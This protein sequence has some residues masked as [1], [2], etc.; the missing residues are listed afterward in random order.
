MPRS[1]STFTRRA[2]YAPTRIFGELIARYG[3][4]LARTHVAADA[5]IIW[6]P[7]LFA[8]GSLNGADFSA[9][10]GATIAM[11]RSCN[12]RGLTCTLV[13][14]IADGNRT[15]G[16]RPL[17]LPLASLGP[18][19]G[20]HA[21]HGHRATGRITPIGT[22]GL[23]RVVSARIRASGNASDVTLLLANDASYAFIVAINPSGARRRIGAVRVRLAN[24]AVVVAGFVLPARGARVIPVGIS[25]AT[26]P[27]AP[28]PR[29]GSPPPFRDPDG[30]SFA[31]GRLRVVFAPFAGARVAE[32][33]DGRT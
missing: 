18:A 16:S 10:A 12:A 17:L 3:A 21:T 15:L 32:L 4:A 8:P 6:P 19:H 24:R 23:R 11:Q 25:A 28:V 9:F 1:P 33:S 7:S 13:D 31:N 30:T 14:L 22:A 20:S 2:R 5:A 29:L 26:P 27:G